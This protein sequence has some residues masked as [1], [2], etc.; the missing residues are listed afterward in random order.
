MIVYTLWF[1]YCNFE[2]I[3]FVSSGIWFLVL[4]NCLYSLQDIR[5]FLYLVLKH[6]LKCVLGQ[7]TISIICFSVIIVLQSNFSDFKM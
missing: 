4:L 2:K 3:V 6:L 5:M 1:L 7:W